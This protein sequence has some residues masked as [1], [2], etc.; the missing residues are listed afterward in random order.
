MELERQNLLEKD[1]NNNNVLKITEAELEK[2]RNLA[3]KLYD[4]L[5]N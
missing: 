1:A 3:S 5:K 4:D 2:Q